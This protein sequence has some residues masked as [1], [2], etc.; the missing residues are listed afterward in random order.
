[1][2]SKGK[3]LLS[4][5]AI[6]IAVVFIVSLTV[7]AGPFG[8]ADLFDVYIATSLNLSNGNVDGVVGSGGNATL[9]AVTL[10]SAVQGSSPGVSVGGTLNLDGGSSAGDIEVAGDTTFSN[11]TQ[12]RSLRTGG[13]FLGI[14]GTLQGDLEAAG[15]IRHERQFLAVW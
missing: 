11:G 12:G 6:A 10:G 8:S 4:V 9:T 14:G 13:D 15:T 3:L 7:Q 1:M 5:E 2:S